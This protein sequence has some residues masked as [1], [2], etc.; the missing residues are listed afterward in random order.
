MRID[1]IQVKMRTHKYLRMESRINTAV[2]RFD[3]MITVAW[4]SE[5]WSVIAAGMN[6]FGG[7]VL[8]IKFIA[9]GFVV[10]SRSLS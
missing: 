2:R 9:A 5:N 7:N 3:L 6:V 10:G 4:C 1:I 8:L